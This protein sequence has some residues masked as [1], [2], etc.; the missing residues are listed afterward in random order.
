MAEVVGRPDLATA[1]R[2]CDLDLWLF[3]ALL[4]PEYA[5]TSFAPKLN[6]SLSGDLLLVIFARNPSVQWWKTVMMMTR[7]MLHT[8]RQEEESW[9]EWDRTWRESRD[10]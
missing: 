3:G 5:F 4:A 2:P 6:R 8:R 10:G 1:A 9:R 7:L